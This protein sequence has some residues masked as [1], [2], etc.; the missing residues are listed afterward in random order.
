MRCAEESY[1]MDTGFSIYFLNHSP[2]L[3]LS[4]LLFVFIVLVLETQP[5]S[6]SRGI[7]EW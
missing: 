6:G 3:S 7:Y 5:V 2:A 4:L 1:S